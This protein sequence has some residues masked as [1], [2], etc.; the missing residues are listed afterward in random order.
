MKTYNRYLKKCEEFLICSECGDANVIGVEDAEERYT[1][2]HIVVKG[3]G[4]VAKAFDNDYM[5]GD[6]N[7]VYFAD[8]K[9]FLGHHTIFE[10]FEPVH[11]Y[12]FN[13]LDLNQDW[14]GKLVEGSFQGD[15][16]SWLICFKGNPIINGK[17]LRVMDYAKLENKHYDVNLND[18]IVGVFTKL[19]D[20]LNKW[21]RQWSLKVSVFYDDVPVNTWKKII[22]DDLHYHVGWG[23]GDLLANSIRY[24][25]Q[26]ISKNDKILDCGCGWGGTAKMLQK[27][28]NCD[29]TGITISKNQYDYIKNNLSMN[30]I[31]SDLHNF[32]PSEEYDVCI[33]VESFCHLGHP[34]KVLDNISKHTK[35]IIL[36]DYYYKTNDYPYDYMNRWL[37]NVRKK[38]E[39]I[40]LFE[41]YNFRLTHHEDHYKNSLEPTVDLWLNNLKKINDNEKSHHIEVLETSARYMKDNLETVLNKIEL[42]TFVFEKND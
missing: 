14:D 6:V 19:D 4:R 16:K 11:M 9:K 37:M 12:G 26:F 17:E 39:L 15:D 40:S 5:V 7:G 38:D 29:V 33:F 32:I 35:K 27:D 3:S 41:K 22:G 1:M 20:N 25:Y 24:L 23:E 18:A 8:V 21:W 30:V 34:S 42:A 28:L 10:S 31:D 2:F 36:R 13:T